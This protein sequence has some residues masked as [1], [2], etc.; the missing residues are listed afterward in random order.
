M[1]QPYDY[2]L[3]IPSPLQAFGQAFNVG[4]AGQKAKY[5]RE[6]REAAIARKEAETLAVN[7]FFNKPLDQR[8]SDDYLQLGRINPQLAEMAQKQ[9]DSK[10]EAEQGVAFRDATQIHTALR[11]SLSG[12]TDPEIVDQIF[13]SRVE[14]TRGDPGLNKMWVDARELAKT[15]P[16]GAEAIV[17]TRIAQLPGGKDYFAAIK[18]LGEESRAAD[19]HSG[20]IEQQRQEIRSNK[21]ATAQI[22]ANMG[23]DMSLL[24]P[25]DVESLGEAAV[26]ALTRL[27]KLTK[28]KQLA[29]AAMDDRAITKI[30]NEIRSQQDVFRREAQA[31]VTKS[32]ED[33]A[34]IDDLSSSIDRVLA[35]GE[36]KSFGRKVIQSA[37]GSLE[38]RAFYPSLDDP[39]NEFERALESIDA[40]GFL[41]Q[42]PKMRGLGQLTQQEGA[43]LTMALGNLSLVQSAD[44]LKRNLKEIQTIMSKA[45]PIA[46]QR[47]GDIKKRIE[48]ASKNPMNLPNLI[49]VE[50]T[51]EWMERPPNTSDDVWS[52]FIN[53]LNKSTRTGGYDPREVR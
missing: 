16:E 23:G 10:S 11:N 5:A 15:N 24:T 18:T 28:R 27:S 19:L 35:L 49:Y 46:E 6:D 45:R 14:A 38:G 1:A 52:G 12:E 43:R 8:T 53:H 50:Q 34:A 3:N 13:A 25:D 37:T 9:W 30:D 40:K 20:A 47:F 51:G 29:E 7:N 44:S 17:G 31:D 22:I 2:T 39:V 48:E 36:V 26:T 41:A 33:L 42:V 32:M 21:F 4:A